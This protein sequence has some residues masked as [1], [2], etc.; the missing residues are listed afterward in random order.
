M[1]IDR[2][3]R[4]GRLEKMSIF[5]C[6]AQT[7]CGAG[8][9][10]NRNV[11]PEAPVFNTIAWNEG[12]RFFGCS[13]DL[14]DGMKRPVKDKQVYTWLSTTMHYKDN[15]DEEDRIIRKNPALKNWT[16]YHRDY[17]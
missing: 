6:V 5:D 4:E 8:R 11:V 14:S 9:G 1:R 10:G 2:R 7:P 12:Y 15:G 3:I 17:L 16:L 13:R